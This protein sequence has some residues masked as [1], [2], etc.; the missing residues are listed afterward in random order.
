[1]AKWTRRKLLT[2]AGAAGV[3]GLGALASARWGIPAWSRH[4]E[5]DDLPPDLRQFV[6]ECFGGLNRS[7]LWDS[8]VHLLGLGDG[9]TGAWVSA[10]MSDPFRPIAR[11]RYEVFREAAGLGKDETHTADE[12][13]V[14]RLLQLH[15]QANPSG[16][17][18]LFAF[19]QYVDE[20]GVPQPE[21]SSFFTPNRYALELAARHDSFQACASI[22]PY[23]EDAVERLR[24]AASDGAV[25][26]KWL[27]N[28]M[29][30]DPASPLCDSFYAELAAVGL[31]LIVHGGSEYAVDAPETQ[32]FGNP[33]RLRRA[34]DAGVRV[35][36]AHCASLGNLEDLDAPEKARVKLPAFRLFERMME[37][38][39]YEE[40]LFG[41]I[42][43]LTQWNRP[44]EA[45]RTFLGRAEFHGR[46]INGSDYPV[47]A[48]KLLFSTRKLQWQGLLSDRDEP[49][50]ARLAD[51]NPLLFDFCL[52]RCLTEDSTR[53]AD[54]VF[55][56]ADFFRA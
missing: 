49:F 30:I 18:V 11:V 52:K 29:G 1:M 22:H 19:D 54:S 14:E 6:E 43:A 27:P 31:P 21:R 9:G 10:E 24:E 5:L 26:V 3:L 37:D 25:A 20:Q 45:L 46:L 53:F 34:L 38:R 8:H 12:S 16:K 17:L 44:T 32:E 7:K 28:G 35:V 51:L 4:G 40:R 36:V 55:E 13:Y 47:P 33:L 41:E 48:V 2:W 50:C 23:R 56:T 42:S 15:A 39:R